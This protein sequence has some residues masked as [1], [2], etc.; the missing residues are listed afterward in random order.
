MNYLNPQVKTLETMLCKSEDD[1]LAEGYKKEDIVRGTD[2]C[3][4]SKEALK[5]DAGL[6]VIFLFGV[7]VLVF[8]IGKT[9]C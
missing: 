9:L 6:S 3:F 5:D 7:L 1:L 2:G 4:Y 8:W